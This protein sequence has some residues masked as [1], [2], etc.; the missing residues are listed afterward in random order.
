MYK[1]LFF[2][3]LALLVLAGVG[4]AGYYLGQSKKPITSNNI[5]IVT[6]LPTISPTIISPAD[7]NYVNI[8]EN[9]VSIG[10]RGDETVL[11]YRGKIYDDSNQ[12]SMEG[13]QSTDEA[14]YKW[15]GLVN[16]TD[17]VTANAFMFDEVFGFKVG[18]DKKQVLFI[19]R[20]GNKDK[21]DTL[22]YYLYYYNPFKYE[23]LHLVKKF[24]LS[25]SPNN[26]PKIG[27]WSEDNEYLSLDIFPC[28]NCGGGI[29]K[30]L[31]MRL[32]NLQEKRI[33]ATSYFKWK[34]NGEY[35]FKENKEIPCPTE[36]QEYMGPCLEKPE[37][38]PLKTGSF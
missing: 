12:L 20:W 13:K 24:I 23:K 16:A 38:L 36:P 25:E 29:P 21:P 1:T 34:T 19:M 33:P 22:A 8:G 14:A 28:W 6:P 27:E 18:S 3:L 31:L 15:Y 26:I 37:N 11:R 2:G 4:F 9:T 32:S 7:T 35:E 5:T 17:E 30:H 10:R